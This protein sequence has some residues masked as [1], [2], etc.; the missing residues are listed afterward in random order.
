MITHYDDGVGVFGPELAIQA[1][2]WLGDPRTRHASVPKGMR[3]MPTTTFFQVLVD[4][5]NAANVVP[6]VFAAKGHDYRADLLPFFHAVLGLQ[7]T[8]SSLTD[9][10]R[11]EE[12]ELFRS[13][14]VK[15]HGTR[16]E[17]GGG[18]ARAADP[19]GTRGRA[20]HRRA[21]ARARARGCGRGV[22]R[23]RSR[24]RLAMRAVI[25]KD[26]RRRETARFAATVEGTQ[27]SQP[28][29]TE[30]APDSPPSTRRAIHI[31]AAVLVGVVLP[32]ALV[33]TLVGHFAANA[34]LLAMFLGVVGSMIG[35][36]RRMVYLAVPFAVAGGLGALTAYD[37][38]WVGL[39]TLLGVVAGAGIRWGWLP[40]LL[41]LPFI[42]T[43][44]SPVS[45]GRH[46]VAYG[47]YAG[48]GLLYGVV[49]A[50]RFKAP[51]VVEGQRLPVPAAVAVA[52][53]MGI[54]LCGTAAIGVALGWTEPYWLPEPIL[55]LTLYILMGKRERI[56]EKA[57]ATAVGVIVAVPV[58]IVAP[59]TWAI[60]VLA[61]AAFV[62]AL[63]QYK[64]SYWRYYSLFTFALVLALSP[65]A[66][67]GAEA[68]QR[69]SEILIGIGVLVVGLG[70]LH[71]L[72]RWL[73]KREPVPVLAES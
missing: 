72:G 33:D 18:R 17:P 38:W 9:T 63:T 23:R 64:K 31:V 28:G 13:Q 45:S 1:P 48:I 10:R 55:I 49:L 46:A 73:A 58:A 51:A 67:V 8:T 19:G 56:R 40:S 47:I 69:G 34:L 29:H 50:R 25:A 44:A 71:A 4:M 59:P 42:A 37:W 21:A 26:A 35:G 60:S 65:P 62:L 5:K 52:A 43:F 27:M 15:K 39:L 36:T 53:V 68:A 22:R 20:R 61:T 54:A 57:L 14:W 7:A 66:H 3:W 6:G 32:V 24:N 30:A 11:L 12:R 41:M 16:Q 70:V 2:E